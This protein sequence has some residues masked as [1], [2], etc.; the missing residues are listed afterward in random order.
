[1]PTFSELYFFH[2]GSQN[3]L[4]EK[5]RQWNTGV[6]WNS[7]L[8]DGLRLGLTADAYLNHVEDKIVA[9]P[10]N[11]FVW[12]MQNL[13]HVRSRGIDMT[14]ST[15]WDFLPNHQLLLSGNYSWQ[16]VE[17]HTDSRSAAYGKQVAYMPEHTWC[18][19]LTWMNPW[20]CL[21]WTMNGQS[22]RWATN[23][24]SPATRMS[25]FAECDLSVWRTL[26][27]GHTECTL[28]A[29]LLNLLD[30]QYEI[31][32]HYPMPGRSWRLSLT[33]RI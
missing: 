19:T 9:I 13:A 2:L 26:V 20:A 3:L 18:A 32:A 6:S 29:T 7:R 27:L 23:E 4:P 15:E 33:I 30:R 24:H 8:T 25:G 17:N 22:C 12:R 21:A 5:T 14:A 31:V 11:T 28:R 16:K 10:F 1:M